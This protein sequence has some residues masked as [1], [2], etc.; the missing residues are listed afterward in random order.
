MKTSVKFYPIGS[1]IYAQNR[2]NFDGKPTNALTIYEA[3]VDSFTVRLN[4]KGKIV[5]EYW[6]KTPD[7]KDWGD[8]VPADQVSDNFNALIARIKPIWLAESSSFGD[9]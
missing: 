4:S 5:E 1:T 8:T 3:V 9:E 2:Y 7:G 6:L